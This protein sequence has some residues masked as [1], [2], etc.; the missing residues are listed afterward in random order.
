MTLSTINNQ[1]LTKFVT[2]LDYRWVNFILYS[3]IL[4]APLSA[5]RCYHSPSTL[6]LEQGETYWALQW[7]PR[8]NIEASWLGSG[9]FSRRTVWFTCQPFTLEEGQGIHLWNLLLWLWRCFYSGLWWLSRQLNT[10]ITQTLALSCGHRFCSDCWKMHC[11][12]KINGQGESRKIEC[13]QSD[14]Q[15]SL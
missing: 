12:E 11:E 9:H 4:N 14:C 7:R 15:V 5:P 3:L 8:Q 2:Y 10:D 1:K 13:M 6:W